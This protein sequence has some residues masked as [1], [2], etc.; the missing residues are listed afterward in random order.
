VRPNSSN[1]SCRSPWALQRARQLGFAS[2]AATPRRQQQ[3]SAAACAR[4]LPLVPSPGRFCAD[5]SSSSS[6]SESG[7]GG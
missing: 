6:D 7:C 5:T 3:T 1:N 2:Q 4:R